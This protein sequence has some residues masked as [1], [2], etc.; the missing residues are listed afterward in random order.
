[1]RTEHRK[2][3]RGGAP[4]SAR[5]RI[6][7][8]ASAGGRTMWAESETF[9]IEPSV[10][11]TVILAPTAGAEV[12]AGEEISFRGEAMTIEHGLLDGGALSWRSRLDG[13]LGSGRHLRASLTSPGEHVVELLARSP[14]GP[15]AVVS[16]RVF[17]PGKPGRAAE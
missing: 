8:G 14:A 1:M 4:G 11:E 13:E 9:E 3:D 12:T 7:V 15:Q 16:T 17:V 2:V 10:P 5:G 6:Q